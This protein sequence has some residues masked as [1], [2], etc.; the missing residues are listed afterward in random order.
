MGADSFRPTG[1]RQVRACWIVSTIA[2]GGHSGTRPCYRGGHQESCEDRSTSRGLLRA[3]RVGFDGPRMRREH[4]GAPICRSPFS[5][6]AQ[7]CKTRMPLKPSLRKQSRR[8]LGS[9]VLWTEWST[10]KPRCCLA[11]RCAPSANA[12]RNR[13]GARWCRPPKR[14]SLTITKLSNAGLR[15]SPKT[16]VTQRELSPT[17]GIRMFSEK[18][19]CEL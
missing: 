7:W 2:G 14:A 16:T 6:R 8:I 17:D 13:V 5:S 19:D 9:T 18:M 12:I 11:S 3:Q 15:R 1:V 10:W 4:A